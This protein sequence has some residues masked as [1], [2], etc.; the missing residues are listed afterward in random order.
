MFGL[1]L[2]EIIILLIVFAVLAFALRRRSHSPGSADG[3][4]EL[5]FEL[6]GRPQSRGW[7]LRGLAGAVLCCM[8]F[9]CLLFIVA[10][11]RHFEEREQG[12]T[13]VQEAEAVALSADV[14]VQS[15]TEALG[16]IPSVIAPKPLPDW[17]TTAGGR[18]YFQVVVGSQFASRQ[19]AFADALDKAATVL[20]EKFRQSH[21]VGR[22]RPD[23]SDVY[24]NAVR[25]KYTDEIIRTAGENEFTVYRTY[26]LVDLSPGV[27]S[28]LESIWRTET[29]ALH[30][31]KVLIVAAILTGIA[32]LL[33]G[34][35]RLDDRTKGRYRWPLIG[36]T[37]LGIV[38]MAVVPVL[39]TRH[40]EQRQQ[41]QSTPEIE[42]REAPQ[43][44]IRI[45]PPSEIRP[46]N[47]HRLIGDG[48]CL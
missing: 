45:V 4:I 11:F 19:D 37:A 18:E 6:R 16:R 48:A 12:A 22:W 33:A 32:A 9:I 44:R 24:T 39:A 25:E 15:R 13:V 2:P 3:D 42:P 14:A 34:F 43:P 46:E 29:K 40:I 5:A 10:Y 7:V 30:R 35:F 41:R 26:L 21:P 8:L 38:F 36:T 31:S 1:G 28:E 23:G 27:L 17:T 20:S 47:P